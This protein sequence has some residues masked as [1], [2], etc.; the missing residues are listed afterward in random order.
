MDQNVRLWIELAFRW[1]HVVAGI[2]WIGHLYFFNWVNSQVAKTYDADSKKKVVPELMPRALY[3]FR[4]GAAYTWITGVL[5][6]GVV[7]SMAETTI[8]PANGPIQNVWALTGVVFGV[9]VVGFFIYDVLWKAMAKQEMAGVAIS[10]VIVAGIAFGLTQI[11]TPRAV[12]ITIGGLFGT[13]MAANVWMRIWPN[14]K[15]IIAATK[16]GTPPDAA[17]AGMAGLRSKHNTYM[18]VPLVLMMVSNHYP[19]AYGFD[20]GGMPLGW[21]ILMVL[22]LVG[23]AVTK[24]LFKKS[25]SPVTAQYGQSAGGEQKAA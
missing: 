25:A 8:V 14:Q 13:S 1:I 22:I 16:A 12:Y 20:A 15:K 24:W 3:F 4:W 9:W 18:S 21:V 5:L 10:F 11:L 23:W 6:A 7:Y 2:T 17:L 19:Q